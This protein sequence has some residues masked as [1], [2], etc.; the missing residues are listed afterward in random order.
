M[1]V[2]HRVLNAGQHAFARSRLMV[3]TA[4]YLRNQANCVI[5][6]RFAAA[7]E[8]DRSGEAWLLQQVAP[9]AH[10]LVDVGANVGDWTA[11][12]LRYG[13]DAR[14]IAF[15]PSHSALGR[16]K[17]RF[18]AHP[19]VVICEAALGESTHVATFAEES[20]AGT[21]SSLI[22]GFADES[23]TLR[24]VEVSTLD[25]QLDRFEVEHVDML[26]VDCEGYDLHVLY[27]SRRLL[28]QQRCDIVQFEYNRPW[29]RAGTTLASAYELLEGCGYR[30]CMLREDGLY[31]FNYELYGEFFEYSNFVALLPKAEPLFAQRFRGA[32]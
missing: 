15:E 18:G 22:R 1:G 24:H 14:I 11:E 20:S 6:Y 21:H 4:V 2:L 9:L 29:A 26:K 3:R 10:T 19:N 28:Q 17:A 8:F 16:L 13:P 5:K 7:P 30:V 32:V 12:A 31:D 23:A 27:G 25:T